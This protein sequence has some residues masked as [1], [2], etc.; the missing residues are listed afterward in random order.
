[1]RP[2]DARRVGVK[3]CC[4]PIDVPAGAEETIVFYDAVERKLKVDTSRSSLGEGPKSVEGGPLDLGPGEALILRV[5]VDRS[6][7]EVFANDRQA[8][9]RRIYPTRADSVSVCLFSEG[10]DVVIESLRAWD[11]APSNPW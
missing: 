6:V 11:M 8:V 7:V 9:M 2:G 5:F 4:S 10:A 3:V 1:M